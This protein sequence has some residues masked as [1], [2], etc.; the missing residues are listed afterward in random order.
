M[1]LKNVI[2]ILVLVATFVLIY[3]PHVE[4]S[5]PLHADE[6][7]HINE[8]TK[9]NNGEFERGLAGYR[10]GFQAL[11]SVFSFVNLVLFYKF[12]AATWVVV[13]SL[14]LFY[15]VKKKT[16][17]FWIAIFSI[18][19]FVSIKSNVNIL[20]LWFFTPLTFSIPFIFLYMFYFTEG[21]EKKNKKYLGISI[22]IMIFLLFFHAISVLFAIPFLIVYALFHL[23]YIKKEWKFFSWFL[24]IPIVGF[25]FYIFMTNLSFVQGVKT[26]FEALQFKK[27]WGVLEFK[28]S[29]LEVYSLIGYVLALVGIIFLG[30]KKKHLAYVL[31]PISTLLFLIIFKFT[32]TS[33]LV[34]FQRNIYYFAISLP[35]LSSIGLFYLFKYLKKWKSPLRGIIKLVLIFVVLFFTFQNYYAIPEQIDVY[36]II[37][38]SDYEALVFLSEFEKT[39]VLATPLSSLAIYPVSGHDVVSTPPLY[40]Y[41]SESYNDAIIFY[42][43][44]DCNVR[45]QIVQKYSVSY[46]LSKEP[47]DCGWKRIYDGKTTVYQT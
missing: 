37:D 42:H 18:L 40:D 38:E 28:N 30:T 36:T 32:G 14:V 33:Y 10:I 20:G 29:F 47:I 46:V 9:L 16:N 15:V 19:F 3:S 24:L 11:L 2:L 34:P 13:S 35:I 26:L 8:A 27:G 21:L 7:H 5:F 23:D 39:T 25:I 12:F 45:N 4:N 1:G 17:S 22:A 44:D 31:W 6:W 41:V 43:V